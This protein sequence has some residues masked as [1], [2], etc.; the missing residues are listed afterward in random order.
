MSP[1]LTFALDP[2][3]PSVA[4]PSLLALTPSLLF[5]W[6]PSTPRFLSLFGFYFFFFLASGGPGQ[7][8]GRFGREQSIHRTD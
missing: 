6:V 3:V 4:S 5:P 1:A 2:R 7:E 8:A